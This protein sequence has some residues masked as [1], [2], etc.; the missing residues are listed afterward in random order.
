MSVAKVIEIV[1]NSEKSFDD[2]IQQG[3]A[4]AAHSLRGIS[5]IEI[6]NWTADV[7]NNQITRYKVTMHVAFKVEHNTTA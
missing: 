7:E 2:A 6:V 4:E 5:G 3:L 1:S